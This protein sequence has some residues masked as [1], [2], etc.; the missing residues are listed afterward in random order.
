MHTCAPAFYM[1]KV[2]STLYFLLNL[3]VISNRPLFSFVNL[4]ERNFMEVFR[5]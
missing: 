4:H 2:D 5:W 3:K 1:M